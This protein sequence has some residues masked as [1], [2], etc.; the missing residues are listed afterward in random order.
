[1]PLRPALSALNKPFSQLGP[2]PREMRRVRCY[3]CG[4]A[5]E[6]SK[7]AMSATCPSCTRHFQFKD[8]NLNQKIEGD[9]STMGHINLE[10]DSEMFGRLVCTELTSEG[11][12]DG[13]A[14]V[15][16]PVLLENTSS[17]TGKIKSS[18]LTI[19][20]GAVCRVKLQVA[21]SPKLAAVTGAKPG[22]SIEQSTGHMN[23]QASAAINH[24]AAQSK[25][26]HYS[27]LKSQNNATP[28]ITS[29]RSRI[30]KSPTN[31]VS[32]GSVDSLADA[33]LPPAQPSSPQRTSSAGMLR[34][35]VTTT[36]RNTKNTRRPKLIQ[37]IK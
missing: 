14:V 21:P 35:P 22:E 5:F 27:Q 28:P 36:I 25:P 15:Y 2:K 1:M 11:R 4:N 18:S 12:F 19:S 31:A 17:T 30:I 9:M 29:P 33:P 20:P 6:V 8:L 37:L 10:A 26:D 23:H 34:P 13:D 3:H 32:A 16:G 7:R 24:P